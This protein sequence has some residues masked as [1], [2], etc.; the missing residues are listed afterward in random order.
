MSDKTEEQI[1]AEKAAADAMRGAKANMEKVLSRC[2]SLEAALRAAAVNL[3]S[4][5]KYIG[6]GCYTYPHSSKPQLARDLI[7]EQAAAADRAAG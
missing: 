2:S 7:E 5:K 6:E 3:R 4:A 1:A